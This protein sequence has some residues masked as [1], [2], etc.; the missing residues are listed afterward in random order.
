MIDRVG[1]CKR[2]FESCTTE[3]QRV[4]WVNFIVKVLSEVEW[5]RFLKDRSVEP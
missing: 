4:I 1:F 2:V 5:M 3:E